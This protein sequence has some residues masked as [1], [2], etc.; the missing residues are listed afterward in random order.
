MKILIISPGYFPIT[1]QQGGAIEKLIDNF[2]EFNEKVGHSIDVYSVK[3][4]KSSFDDDI[5]KNTKFKIIDKT[6]KYK[7]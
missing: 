4:S 6:K 3:N 7:M 5:Y 1:K 2:L